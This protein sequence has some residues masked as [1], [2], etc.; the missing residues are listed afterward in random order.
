MK[1][2]I[3]PLLF[4]CFIFLFNISSVFAET[5]AAV[6]FCNRETVKA[7]IFIGDI[8][9]IAKV[10]IPMII[11]IL[12]MI[13]FFKAMLSENESSNKEATIALV[14]RIIAGIAIFLI[15]TICYAI[16]ELIASDEYEDYNNNFAC[17]KCVLNPGTCDDN[18]IG[19]LPEK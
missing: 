11:I 8:I 14:R 15:P 18:F 3:S 17:A 12:G 7:F 6:S 9:S 13:A 4:S 16:L 19:D 1:K 10:L 2:R 5:E